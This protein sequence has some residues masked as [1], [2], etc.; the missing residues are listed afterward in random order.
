M[1]LNLTLKNDLIF[2]H[3][4]S[5]PLLLKI[6]RDNTVGIVRVLMSGVETIWRHRPDNRDNPAPQVMSTQTGLKSNPSLPRRI[7]KLWSFKE[8]SFFC[9]ILCFLRIILKFIHIF[10]FK[11]QLLFYT[12]SLS[13]GSPLE[14]QICRLQCRTIIQVSDFY[15]PFSKLFGFSSSNWF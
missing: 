12:L 11:L 15:S 5:E 10:C 9:L 6:P 7:K 3:F 4:R 1:F 8:D 13:F 14:F 2:C